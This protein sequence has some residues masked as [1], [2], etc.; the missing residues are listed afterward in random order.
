MRP[1][2]SSLTAT[3]SLLLASLTNCS[4]TRIAFTLIITYPVTDFD[5]IYTCMINFQNASLQKALS[6]A[7][8]GVMKTSPAL[9][10][11]SSG[12]ILTNSKILF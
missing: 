3:K 1:N 8:Y 4:K 5:T 9:Q 10:K 7:H 2:I 11:S 6:Q 12:Y